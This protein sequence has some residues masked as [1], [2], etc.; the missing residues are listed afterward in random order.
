MS[1]RE[2]SIQFENRL[3]DSEIEE[4]LV[5]DSE[6]ENDYNEDIEDIDWIPNDAASD[7][8]LVY[9]EVDLHESDDDDKIEEHADAD[10]HEQGAEQEDSDW[11]ATI[12]LLGPGMTYTSKDGT[13]W[14]KNPLPT[15]RT[16]LHN[17]LRE[18]G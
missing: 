8:E 4:L 5:S 17:I 3:T 6:G 7:E 11:N 18:R 10:M 1:S 12:N 15:T 2:Y 16:R 13:T 9:N 14:A